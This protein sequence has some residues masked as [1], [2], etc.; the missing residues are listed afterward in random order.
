MN[1]YLT[2]HFWEYEQ[3]NPPP[4]NLPDGMKTIYVTDKKEY[5]SSLLEMGW[6]MVSIITDYVN[7]TDLRERRLII[8]EINC[9]PLKFIPKLSEFKYIFICDSNVITLWQDYFNFVNTCTDDKC[10]FTT[11]DWYGGERNNIISEYLGSNHSRWKYSY[12]QMGLSKDEYVRIFNNLGVDV[13]SIGVCSAKYFGWNTHHPMY[14]EISK[15]F[16]N[17][18]T[19]HIQ[20]NIILSYIGVVYDNFVLKYK[21][22]YSGGMVSHHNFDA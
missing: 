13:N 10:L 7:V 3:L 6:D 1:I 14:S 5:E 2:K 19:K 8:S 11:T 16:Y 15:H 21:G 4:K 18:Y 17:E 12:E 9:F 22:D 20:G